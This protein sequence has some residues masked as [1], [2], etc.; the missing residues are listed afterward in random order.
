MTAASSMKL[1]MRKR[2]MHLGQASG[3]AAQTF[4][5]KRARA[6]LQRWRKPPGSG[7]ETAT[8]VIPGRRYCRRHSPWVLPLW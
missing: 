4:R 1:M 5:I 3:S 6:G 7:S 8:G 2:A